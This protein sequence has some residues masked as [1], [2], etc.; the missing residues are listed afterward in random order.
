MARQKL[1]KTSVEAI[2]PG[3]QDV[4]VWDTTLPGFGVRVKPTG[5][6]SYI[7]QYRNRESGASKRLTIGQHGSL[8]T[9][10]QAKKQARGAS[11]R[12]HARQGSSRGTPDQT[13]RADHSRHGN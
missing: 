1:T 11:G 4:V 6:R 12:S 13:Y 10:E 3:P 2:A 7:V 9:L 5:V 8:L